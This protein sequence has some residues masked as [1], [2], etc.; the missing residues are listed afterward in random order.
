M[1]QPINNET[2]ASDRD[3]IDGDT[4]SVRPTTFRRFDAQDLKDE[5]LGEA[6]DPFAMGW[7]AGDNM[8]DPLPCPF[9]DGAL[10]QLWRK[11]YCARVDQY[12]ARIK[13]AGG[14]KAS[15]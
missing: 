13:S 2:D 12:I 6:L 11:G 14:L 3:A 10:A 5:T 7:D 8:D 1:G 4:P 15:L 9:D